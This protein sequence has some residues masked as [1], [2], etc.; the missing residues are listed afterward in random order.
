MVS[1]ERSRQQL[2]DTC[3]LVLVLESCLVRGN[4][5]FKIGRGG[6]L[7]CVTCC[8]YVSGAMAASAYQRPLRE[9]L[10]TAFL[11]PS[12]IVTR[13]GAHLYYLEHQA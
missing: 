8:T 13:L 11:L 12:T 1:L 6:V 7:S 10:D 2:S 4:R 5:A 9:T 3:R